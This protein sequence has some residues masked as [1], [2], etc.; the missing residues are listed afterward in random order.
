MSKLTFNLI[1]GLVL[2]CCLTIERDNGI[3]VSE[4]SSILDYKESHLLFEENT[5]DQM[6]ER[7]LKKRLNR[8]KISK[9]S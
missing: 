5:F 9:L 1:L 4:A 7:L 2:F 6:P 8:Y 3:E